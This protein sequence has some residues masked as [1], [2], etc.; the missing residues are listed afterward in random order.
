MAT[1][2]PLHMYEEELKIIINNCNTILYKPGIKV[3]ISQSN[4]TNQELIDWCSQNTINCFL[5]NREHLFN[6]GLCATT[7]QAIMSERPL[8]VSKDRTFRHIHKYL[9]YYPNISIKE[10]IETTLDGVKKM[11]SEWSSEN[12]K[13]K[14][15]NILFNIN[16]I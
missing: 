6:S 16:L 10:A 4:F 3:E 12:F 8:L 7:D 15:E 13:N 11:K 2:V 14:F 9:N 1:F 5:Y